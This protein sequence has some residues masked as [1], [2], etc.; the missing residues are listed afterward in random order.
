M[1]VTQL[2]LE[3]FRATRRYSESLPSIPDCD[4]CACQSGYIYADGCYIEIM[5]YEGFF[6]LMVENQQWLSGDLAYLE[7]MLYKNWY[8]YYAE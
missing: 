3:A 2:T 1:T 4:G 8:V 5:E 7:E 6:Y